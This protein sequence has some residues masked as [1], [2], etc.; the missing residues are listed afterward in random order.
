MIKKTV[1]LMVIVGVLVSLNSTDVYGKQALFDGVDTKITCDKEVYGTNIDGSFIMDCN[2]ESKKN[3]N[4]KKLNLIF[5]DFVDGDVDNVEIIDI[6][7]EE[8]GKSKVK[9]KKNE[10]SKHKIGQESKHEFDKGFTVKKNDI[11]GFRI[12]VKTPFGSSGKFDFQF[13]DDVLDPW[14]NASW[15]RRQNFTVSST[16]SED[17]YQIEIIMNP[18]DVEF[19]KINSDCSDLRFAQDEDQIIPH[20]THICDISGGLIR[21][22]VKYNVSSGEENITMYYENPS[23]NTTS[24]GTETML[25]YDTFDSNVSGWVKDAGHSGSWGW[26]DYI[27]CPNGLGNGC[28][29]STEVDGFYRQTGVDGTSWDNYSFEATVR[30]NATTTVFGIGTRFTDGN[31][32]YWLIDNHV[33]GDNMRI[34]KRT[35]SVYTIINDS[36]V[37]TNIDTNYVYKFRS[38]GTSLKSFVDGDLVGTSTD[39]DHSNGTIGI[40]SNANV[41]YML[42]DDAIAYKSSDPEPEISPQGII[43]YDEYV[44]EEPEVNVTANVS[45]QGEFDFNVP[46]TD[47]DCIDNNTLRLKTDTYLCTGDSCSWFNKT[48]I[49]NCE[50]GCFDEINAQ[51]SGCS[52]TTFD[53]LIMTMVILFAFIGLVMF[54]MGKKKKRK[55]RGF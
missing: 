35:A 34:F 29:W 24:N 33:S 13:G 42:L 21:A 39:S 26:A 12:K 47:A 37:S 10:L 1:F 8:Q 46:V 51:G 43:T 36:T 14:F 44:G 20:Y 52:P 4:N 30:F 6:E 27:G 54:L 23:A 32:N 22:F 2:I 16:F 48:Q 11:V 28:F 17:D 18:G 15:N 50:N 7:Y 49:I 31:N 3:L 45:I 25:Y 41:G 55:R 38:V 40:I 9:A 5:K 53:V 19:I